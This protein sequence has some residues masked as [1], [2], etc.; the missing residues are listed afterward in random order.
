[1]A[2]E[3]VP[4]IG[5]HFKDVAEAGAPILL[6]GEIWF[7]TRWASHAN[8]HQ[9]AASLTSLG[10]HVDDRCQQ[11]RPRTFEVELDA[12]YSFAYG[13]LH[14]RQVRWRCC[15]HPV[16]RRIDVPLSAEMVFVVDVNAWRFVE[17]HMEQKKFW[18]V[19]SENGF[20]EYGTSPLNKVKR[21]ASRD[22][23]TA[24]AKARAR[25]QS[26]PHFVLEAVSVSE[27]VQVTT[28]DL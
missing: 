26:T 8:A 25:E 28:R 4:I 27:A 7:C 20:P 12:Y 24:S 11:C 9:V 23:A 3:P 10:P 5:S 18:V 13:L 16:S 22:D 1:M 6:D 14:P 15:G 19:M 21:Y 2:E 17:E